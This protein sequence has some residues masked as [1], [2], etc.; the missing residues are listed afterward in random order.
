MFLKLL[1]AP[2][3][4]PFHGTVWLAGELRD[5]AERE[6]NDPARLRAELQSLEQALEA[7]DIDEATF[8]ELEED[9][10]LRLQTAKRE[11]R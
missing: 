5:A 4:A 7:G 11:G 8:E 9:L 2:F 1:S 3:T 10:I 6:M